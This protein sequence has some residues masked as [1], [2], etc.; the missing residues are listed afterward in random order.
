MVGGYTHNITG[1]YPYLGKE[2]WGSSISRGCCCAV[3]CVR[4]ARGS[5][6]EAAAAV[7]ETAPCA[8]EAAEAA[9]AVATTTAPTL[10]Q[11]LCGMC[12]LDV[13]G[14]DSTDYGLEF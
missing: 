10:Q 9:T 7:A 2:N 1:A 12:E 13:R 8:P 5:I 4:R 11:V 6:P 14:S 3:T